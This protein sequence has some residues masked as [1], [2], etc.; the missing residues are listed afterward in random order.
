[1]LNALMG[2]R[3]GARG[4]VCLQRAAAFDGVVDDRLLVARL[5]RRGE[6]VER[7]VAEL[8][9]PA[10]DVLAVGIVAL[11]L[12]HGVVQAPADRGGVYADGGDPLP[13]AVVVGLVAVE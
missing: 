3:L 12:E 9:A 13:V 8:R 4:G 5:P 11:L 7:H 6:L 2:C 10:P 1:M